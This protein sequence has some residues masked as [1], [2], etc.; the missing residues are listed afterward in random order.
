MLLDNLLP[1]SSRQVHALHGSISRGKSPAV[2]NLEVSFY[3]AYI[4]NPV[5]QE[6]I[7]Q[8]RRK[9]LS[10]PGYEAQDEQVFFA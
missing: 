1:I 3:T 2:Q 7:K 5:R 4:I 9:F 6:L 10:K 8:I